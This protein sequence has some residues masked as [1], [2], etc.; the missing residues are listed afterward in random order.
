MKKIIGLVL[1][2]G[3]ILALIYAISGSKKS[4]NAEIFEEEDLFE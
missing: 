2:I 3:A 4:K 1:C